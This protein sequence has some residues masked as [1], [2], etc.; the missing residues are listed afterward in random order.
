MLS[1]AVASSGCAIVTSLPD[2]PTAER[3][4]VAHLL[5]KALLP[6][7]LIEADGVMLLRMG[8]PTLAGDPS[9][10]YHAVH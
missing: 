3:K 6:I 1:I 8:K 7:E 10:R 5:P 4:G 2:G 9:Q